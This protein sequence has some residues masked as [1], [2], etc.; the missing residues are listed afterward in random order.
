MVLLHKYH[1]ILNNSY[2]K[3]NNIYICVIIINTGYTLVVLFQ[4]GIGLKPGTKVETVVPYIEAIDMVLIMTVEPGFGGQK[5]MGDMMPKV[6]TS[7]RLISY[8]KVAPITKFSATFFPV[9]FFK[10]SH[11]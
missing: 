10:S 6:R 3:Y 9:E 8:Q 5:F 4:V 7:L 1:L 11:S 2:P